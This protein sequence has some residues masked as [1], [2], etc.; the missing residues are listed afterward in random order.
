M[1]CDS[2]ANNQPDLLTV[3]LDE[4]FM[5]IRGF[6]FPDNATVRGER[7]SLT[8]FGGFAWSYAYASQCHACANHT[9]P[10]LRVHSHSPNCADRQGRVVQ[11]A[12]F[13]SRSE[14]LRLADLKGDLS[15]LNSPSVTGRYDCDV[16]RVLRALIATFLLYDEKSERSFH[17]CNPRLTRS[18]RTC[19]R[20]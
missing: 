14:S 2:I 17:A 16:R 7:P 18:S 15:G 8:G 4:V 10:K 19:A 1:L 3:H 6:Q 12:W 20:S 13:K 9:P 11:I 5:G